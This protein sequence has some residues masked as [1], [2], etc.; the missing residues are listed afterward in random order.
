MTVIPY[1]PVLTGVNYITS[2]QNFINNVQYQALSILPLM[3][4]GWAGL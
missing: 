4:V 2:F 1:K 3:E